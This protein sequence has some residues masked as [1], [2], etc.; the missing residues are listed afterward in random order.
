MSTPV[1]PASPPDSP[2]PLASSQPPSSQPTDAPPSFTASVGKALRDL[3]RWARYLLAGILVVALV[4]LYIWMGHVE[5]DDAQVDAHITAVAPQVPGYV[6]SLTIDDNVNVKVGDVLLQI[7]PREYQAEV[8]QAKA[9]LDLAE[10]EARSAELAI[11]L[12]RG[13]TTHSTG[14][15]AAQ[16]ESD[17][18]DYT[19]AQAQLEQA[20]TANLLQS[21]AEVAAKRATNERAQAD[22]A[23]YT[24]L[25]Q[26]GDVSKFQFDSVEATARVSQND[27]AAAE[28]QLAA[29]QQGVEIAQA[30]ANSSKARLARSQSLLM[31]SKAREQQVPITEATYKSALAAVEHAQALLDQAKLNLGY[32]T[33]TAPITGQVTQKTVTLDSTF[34]PVTCSSPWF[35]STRFISP[36]TS[37]KPKWHTCAQVSA[38]RYMTIP[39]AATLT[40]SW[41]PSPARLALARRCCLHR[42]PR[43][44]SLRWY[45]AF[46]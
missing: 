5:T 25:L 18:A 31:E 41:T 20:A 4:A 15:A 8:D 2:A 35:L 39:I 24:P 7:D 9:T 40:A 34:C 22:L 29:A 28:Q 21:K 45:S 23:R 12:T 6:V 3:P 42:T 32:T 33:I 1:T 17:A 19:M 46:R 43:A 16:H 30:N 10:A 13:T 27:L 44:T 38:P 11:G 37:R 36:Q 14:G 26:T